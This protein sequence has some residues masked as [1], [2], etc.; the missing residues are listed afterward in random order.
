MD[1][2]YLFKFILQLTEIYK[3]YDKAIARKKWN[4]PED[5]CILLFA[6]HGG[7]AN[8]MKGGSYMVEAL[9]RLQ[10]R[11]PQLVFVEVGGQNPGML[12][13]VKLKTYSFPYI[14]QEEKMAEL[15][16]VADIFVS[17][18]LTESFGLTV[19]EAMA[20][21]V[22]VVSFATGGL[23]ELVVDGETGML[24]PIGAVE[25][26]AKALAK[27]IVLPII[28]KQKGLSSRE[29]VKR[30]FSVEVFCKEYE[31]IYDRLDF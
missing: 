28:C 27:L 30:M 10:D 4:L 23:M 13:D 25:Q 29:R 11:Y 21:G 5:A 15:Y 16:S 31:K 18:S 19:C 1:F 3:P 12:K 17:T 24:V 8:A 7:L 14:E 9:K 2:I 26:L 20:C 22:T 6:A